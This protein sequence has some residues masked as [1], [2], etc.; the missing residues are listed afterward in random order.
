MQKLLRLNEAHWREKDMPDIEAILLN[1][2]PTAE[3][4]FHLLTENPFRYTKSDDE[5]LILQEKA[6]VRSQNN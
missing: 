4:L 2:Q 1:I 6:T 5:G 3:T